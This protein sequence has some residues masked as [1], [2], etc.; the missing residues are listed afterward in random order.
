M[1]LG[2]ADSVA[3]LDLLAD[4]DELGDDEAYPAA[5]LD[6]LSAIV[7]NDQA[8]YQESDLAARRF[9]AISPAEPSDDDALYWTVGPCPIAD[10]RVRTGD[11]TAVRMSD[12]IG[13]A[14]FR[15]LPIYREY[16]AP[17]AIDHVLDLGLGVGRDRYRSLVLLRERDAGEFSERDRAVLETLRPHLRARE[18]RVAL[19][20]V[21]TG[22][23]EP[24]P[25]AASG[26][27][28]QL[29]AREREIVMLVAQG[30]TNPEIATELWVTPGTVKKHLEHVYQKLGVGSRAAAAGFVR[31]DQRTIAS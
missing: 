29:T 13:R 10:Y 2:R 3:V 4:I 5:L 8:S 23:T 14:R 20:H 31:T 11:A 19:R 25:A 9:V 28:P 24:A 1:Q 27:Q 21:A 22:A 12:V 26:E 30:R 17:F 18:A 16:F 7:P 15:E 6:L